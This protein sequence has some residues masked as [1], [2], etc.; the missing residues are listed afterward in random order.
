[1]TQFIR[2]SAVGVLAVLAALTW[3]LQ[4]LGKPVQQQSSDRKLPDYTMEDVDLTALD[5]R[6]K[7]EMKLQ[8]K[9]VVHYPED[10]SMDLDAPHALVFEEEGPPWRVVAERGWVSDDLAVVRLLGHAELE[11]EA[12][13]SSGPIRVVTRDVSIQTEARFIETDRAVKAW[14]GA[15]TVEAVG[16]RLDLNRATLSLLAHVQGY[17]VPQ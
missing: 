3:W 7:P 17:Y 1:M 4:E 6:G 13:Q 8:A 5:E 16:M 9:S 10:R 12:W 2:W 14:M 15:N 11:R